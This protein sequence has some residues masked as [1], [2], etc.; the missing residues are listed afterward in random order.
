M[1][2]QNSQQRVSNTPGRTARPVAS[3]RPDNA[4]STKPTSVRLPPLQNIKIG[5][6]EITPLPLWQLL[7]IGLLGL[8]VEF[9][10][11]AGEA[12]IIPYLTGMGL[13][14]ELAGLVWL[15]NPMIAVFFQP[16]LGSLSDRCT[17]KMGRRRPFI[18][19]LTILGC[20]GI[21]GLVFG[22]QM[23]SGGSGVIALSFV[24]YALADIAHNCLIGF[25]RMLLGDLCLSEQTQTAHATFSMLQMFGRLLALLA[26]I[27]N[28][29]VLFPFFTTDAHTHSLLFLSF[30][31]LGVCAAVACFAAKEQPLE[32]RPIAVESGYS[33][34]SPLIRSPSKK[35]GHDYTLAHTPTETEE[36]FGAEKK[37]DAWWRLPADLYELLALTFFG[38]VAFMAQGFYWTEWIG[39]DTLVPGT[40][41]REAFFTLTLFACASM[42]TVALMPF[43]NKAGAMRV[44]VLG[45]L[46]LMSAMVLTPLVENVTSASGVMVAS[47]I[48]Y[49]IHSNNSFMLCD[50]LVDGY[51]E[52]RRGLYASLVNATLTVGQIIVGAFAGLMIKCMNGQIDIFF[53]VIGVA[54]VVAVVATVVLARFFKS[55]K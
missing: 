12:V 50:Q 54:G 39:L 49:A 9:C 22:P 6:H 37:K 28:L 32:H 41:M 29:S 7:C 33:E 48:A 10:W 4:A 17:L 20:I 55:R 14:V 44:F 2:F 24:A 21:L 26:G 1:E 19:G 25:G 11:A 53:A 52:E 16:L 40:N 47:G 27:V 8:S 31:V 34:K 35:R 3:F 30:W 42:V 13:P 45:Q 51:D 18:I 46:L 38:W 5:A 23:V 36:F 43:L 15:A